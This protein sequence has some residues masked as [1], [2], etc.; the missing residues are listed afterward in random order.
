M[1]AF[2]VLM[3]VQAELASG[4]EAQ[5]TPRPASGPLAAHFKETPPLEATAAKADRRAPATETTAATVVEVLA[6]R[7]ATAVQAGLSTA[8]STAANRQAAKAGTAETQAPIGRTHLVETEQTAARD[9]VEACTTQARA[10]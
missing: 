3:A 7:P 2:T 1:R 9:G 6:V 8:H 5:S 10:T 4:Q